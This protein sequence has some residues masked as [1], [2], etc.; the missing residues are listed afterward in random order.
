MSDIVSK[1]SANSKYMDDLI[2]RMVFNSASIEGNTIT[3]D[4]T[5]SLLLDG[6]IPNFRRRVGLRE[7]Y[8]LENIRSA[9]QYLILRAEERITIGLMHKVHELV[10]NNIEDEAGKFKKTQNMVGGK[11]TTPPERVHNEIYHLLDHLYNGTLIYAKN[12]EDKVKATVSFHIGF[13]KIHPYSDGNGRT[14]RLLLNHVLLSQ[15]IAPFI[16]RA[17]DKAL[18]YKYLRENDVMGL[19]AYALERIK[20]EEELINAIS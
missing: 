11:L 19:T 5:R 4:E 2:V 1:M 3:I 15:N 17:E 14:G 6:I 8:E 18:Y 12:M 13:E 16:I 9:W 20:E 10:M 7:V